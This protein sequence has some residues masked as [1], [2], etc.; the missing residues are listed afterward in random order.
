MQL[1]NTFSKMELTVR[2]FHV[3]TIDYALQNQTIM[4][5][6]S[7]VLFCTPLPETGHWSRLFKV[8]TNHKTAILPCETKSREFDSKLLLAC[9]LAER[10]WRVI[11]GSRNHIHLAL[12]RLPRSVYL[13][14]DVRHSSRQIVRILKRLG[15]VFIAQ[16]EEAQFYFSRERYR[17]AR[18]HPE[19][20]QAAKC[21][22]AW[23]PD[24]A[25]AWQEAPAYKGAPI[26]LTGNGRIDLM[27]PELRGLHEAKTNEYRKKYGRIILVN[28][29]F[30]AL[31]HFYTNLT[32]LAPPEELDTKEK[33]W[34]AGLSRHRYTIFRAF[35]AL[36]PRLASRFPKITFILRPHPGENHQTWIDAAQG[37]KNV[38]VSH[39]GSVIPWILASEALIHN[40]CTTGLEAYILDGRPIAYQPAVSEA[41]DLHLPNALSSII[42][43]EAA[44]F[45]L[46]DA[47]IHKK[48]DQKSLHTPERETLLANHISAIHGPLASERI[49]DAMTEAAAAADLSKLSF[50]PLWLAGFTH[51]EV[52]AFLKRRHMNRPGHK[53][54]IAYT[55]HRFPDTSLAEVRLR[56]AGLTGVLQRFHGVQAEQYDDNIFSIRTVASRQGS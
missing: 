18:V 9:I 55:K 31:N 15:H 19:V 25:R 53:A 1:Q 49:A 54:N 42:H 12:G 32:V 11:V 40:S 46:V 5:W 43:D 39:E 21:L 29:N 56:I 24:N 20:L 14:K 22:L 33:T 8:L 52:R 44:L 51:A 16:D 4:N 34:E 41:Y 28:T 30:S 47:I 35:L 3:K 45:A 17:K 27:R 36:L 2:K 38:H 26:H 37:A 10:G 50:Q 7:L 6:T 23:G 48:F 13:G